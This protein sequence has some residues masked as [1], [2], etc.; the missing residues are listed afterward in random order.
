[1]FQQSIHYQCKANNLT[2]SQNKGTNSTNQQI[3]LFHKQTNKQTNKRECFELWAHTTY[4][5]QWGMHRLN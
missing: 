5:S 4:I 3:A 2:N 1:M